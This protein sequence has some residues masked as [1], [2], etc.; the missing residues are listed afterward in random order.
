MFSTMEAITLCPYIYSDNDT[1]PCTRSNNRNKQRPSLYPQYPSRLPPY[2]FVW[3]LWYGAT[4]RLSNSRIVYHDIVTLEH[5]G[6]G[7]M[8]E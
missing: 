6:Y 1:Y 5:K 7:M 4:V 2:C 3:V 8:S